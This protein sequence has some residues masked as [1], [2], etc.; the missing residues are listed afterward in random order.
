MRFT[1]RE[2]AKKTIRSKREENK[3]REEW[4][5]NTCRVKVGTKMRNGIKKNKGN[6]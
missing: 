1:V 4:N 6:E 3:N 5:K 2:A